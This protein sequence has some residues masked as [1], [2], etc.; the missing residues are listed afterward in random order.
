MVQV[1]PT[2]KP[3]NLFELK[4]VSEKCFASTN[5]LSFP[6]RFKPMPTK[7]TLSVI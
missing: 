2:Q 1:P 5:Q 3:G 7:V 4:K 6:K